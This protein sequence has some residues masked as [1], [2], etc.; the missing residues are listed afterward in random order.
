MSRPDRVVILGAG[1][2]GMSAAYH[3]RRGKH[4][5]VALFEKETTP[6]GLVRSKQNGAYRFDYTGHFLHFR[7]PKIAAQ[8]NEWLPGELTTVTRDAW[9]HSHRVYTPYP[10]QTN[11]YGLPLPVVNECLLGYIA[12]RDQD[13]APER[14]PERDAPDFE[15]WIRHSVGNGIARHFMIPYN[16]KLWGVPPSAM[17][18]DWMNRFVPPAPLDKVVAGA[19]G[20]R[21]ASSG[22]NARFEY[23]RH[24]GIQILSEAWARHAGP[25]E[26]AHE[27]VRIDAVN[28]RVGFDTGLE[29]DYQTLISTLPL[30]VLCALIAD[31]PEPVRAACDRL[32]WSSVWALCL[33]IKANHT[34]GRHWVYVPEEKYPFYRVG[35]F[36]NIAPSMAPDGHSSVWVEQ[37]YN[38]DRPLDAEQ[39]RADAISGLK[40]MGWL[41]DESEIAVEWPLRMPYAYVIYDAHHAEATATI[42][43]FLRAHGILSTGRYGKWDYSSMEDAI[44]YGRDA[45]QSLL[46]IP[47]NAPTTP[48]PGTDLK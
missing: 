1:L 47:Q 30:P 31:L 16:T 19:L 44:L 43:E 41:K 5:N 4:P 39:A 46:G 6:G 40:D 27:A 29:T 2:T 22:Y 7:D 12:A 8:V 26:Y 34:G 38:R 18:T 14:T 20:L 35:C 48:S 15:T 9:I 17:T 11:L 13:R 21:D 32:S 24:G 36:S 28:R 37:S 33:G 23:P 42:H 45:A 3:L 10:F 25:I